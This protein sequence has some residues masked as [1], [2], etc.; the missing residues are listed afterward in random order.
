M[1][2]KRKQTLDKGVEARRLA[3]KSG[4]APAV[5]RVIADKRK[6]AP[7]HRKDMLQEEA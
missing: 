3:R 5:T 2:R 6:K 7:K 1:K 4:L